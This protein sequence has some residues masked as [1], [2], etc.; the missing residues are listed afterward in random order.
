MKVELGWRGPVGDMLGSGAQRM[1]GKRGWSACRAKGRVRGMQ[2]IMESLLVATLTDCHTD[3][4]H[5][6][7][8]LG[9]VPGLVPAAWLPGQGWR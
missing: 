7:S 3:Y 1:A 9:P 5:D 8:V 4:P 2:R 6:T